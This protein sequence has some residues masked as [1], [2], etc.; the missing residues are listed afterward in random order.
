MPNDFNNIT[1]AIDGTVASKDAN[2]IDGIAQIV[3]TGISVG[4]N[5]DSMNNL[6][7]NR[8]FDVISSQTKE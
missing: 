3:D 6:G 2:N 5:R 1:S 4:N 8:T 7:V